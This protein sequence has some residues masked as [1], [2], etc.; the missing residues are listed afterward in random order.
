MRMNTDGLIIKEH[1]TSGDDRLV[2]VP[3]ADADNEMRLGYIHLRGLPLNELEQRFVDILRR[4]L[5]DI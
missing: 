4:I 3:L 2:T 5:E 1:K